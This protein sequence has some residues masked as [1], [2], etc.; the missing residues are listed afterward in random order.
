M[1][2]VL[3]AI[4]QFLHLDPRIYELEREIE[5]HRYI[6]FAAVLVIIL[7]MLVVYLQR[8][9]INAQKKGTAPSLLKRIKPKLSTKTSENSSDTKTTSTH[10]QGMVSPKELPDPGL[11]FKYSLA[12]EDQNEK[13]I[14][15]G[16]T[17]GNIKTYSTEVINNHLA[18]TI[19]I[20]ENKREQD[21]YNLPSQIVEEYLLNI[22]REGK[23]L[24]Y[25]PGL[26]NFREMSSRERFYLTQKPDEM[27]DPTF[28]KL[29]PKQPIRFRLGDRLNQDGKFIKGYFEFHLFTQDYEVKTK[30]GIPKIEKN[31]LL[32]LYKIYP[33]YD[34]GAPTDDGLYPMIDPFTS[35]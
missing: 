7:L 5:F 4:C 26:E 12:K 22:R 18:I 35:R 16:Q 33:G 24:I 25:Y 9:I 6:I 34:T 14:I 31:F 3:Y 29:D 30:S 32:R 13:T 21:I 11:I 19:R 8:K 10:R 28:E 1:R 2:G 27:G 15:I 20:I 17:E 23:V